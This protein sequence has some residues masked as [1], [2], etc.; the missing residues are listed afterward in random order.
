LV[1]G[2]AASGSFPVFKKIRPFVLPQDAGRSANFRM[3]A[4]NEI[5]LDHFDWQPF[6]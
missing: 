6:A 4:E 1:E 2:G 5:D 3:Q